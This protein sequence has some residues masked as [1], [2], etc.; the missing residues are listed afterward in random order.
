MFITDVLNLLFLLPNLIYDSPFLLVYGTCL[1]K[2]RISLQEHD[3]PQ[4]PLLTHNPF[5]SVKNQ[6]TDILQQPSKSIATG[7]DC[8][9]LKRQILGGLSL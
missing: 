2:P 8:F 3:F 9:I 1:A 7:G 5:L 4:P 6:T